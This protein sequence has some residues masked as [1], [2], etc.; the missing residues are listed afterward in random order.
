VTSRRG[1]GA[2]GSQQR[3][4][5]LAGGKFRNFVAR[6]DERTF[7]CTKCAYAETLTVLFS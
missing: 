4:F 2:F 7:E 3:Q 6:Y 1:P 5:R